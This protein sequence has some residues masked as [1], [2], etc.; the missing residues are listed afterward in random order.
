MYVFVY[1]IYI[2]TYVY[3]FY[4]P[5]YFGSLLLKPKKDPSFDYR[6]SILT[7]SDDPSLLYPT[8][9]WFLVQDPF[10]IGSSPFVL[11]PVLPFFGLF[12]VGLSILPFGCLLFQSSSARFRTYTGTGTWVVK[13]KILKGMT[14]RTCERFTIYVFQWV[15]SWNK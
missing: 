7:H 6:P 11:L 1:I 13:V 10:T 14:L 12:L 15:A 4:W 8:F 9:P 3:V 2:Q 5:S